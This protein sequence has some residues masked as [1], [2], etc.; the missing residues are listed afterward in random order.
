MFN[1]TVMFPERL[2]AV[3]ARVKRGVFERAFRLRA[4]FS[5]F[6]FAA[7]LGVQPQALSAV[8]ADAGLG[9]VFA[10]SILGRVGVPKGALS[11]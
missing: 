9:E 3:N 8:H 6:D 5:V 1:R 2:L 4:A 11:S 10:G 7:I